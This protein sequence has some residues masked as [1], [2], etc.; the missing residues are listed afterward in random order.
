MDH[1]FHWQEQRTKTPDGV[2]GVLRTAILDGT[3]HPGEQLRETHI[4][5]DLGISRSPLREALTRL[6]EE[7]LILKIPFRG[8]FVA[9]VSA[10]DIAEIAAVRVLLEPYAAELAAPT[11]QGPE[12]LRLKQAIA[13]LYGA[14][15]TNDIPGSVDAHLRFHRLFY[16]FSGNAVLRGL[17]NGWENKLRLYL[18]IDHPTYSDLHD[19]AVE[20]ERLAALALEGNVDG[21][22]QEMSNQLHNAL[23]AQTPN[24]T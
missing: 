18:S 3:L 14:A 11:L 21:F 20:H 8:S 23:R 19:I 17:W 9:E 12:R 22:R 13:E 24:Q 1:Q 10:H 6:E 15:D 4:A 16:Q 2:Y 5:A 7:G